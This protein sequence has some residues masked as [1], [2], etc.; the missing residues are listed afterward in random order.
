MYL[1]SSRRSKLMHQLV[2][3]YNTNDKAAKLNWKFP[4]GIDL[5]TILPVKE[6]REVLIYVFYNMHK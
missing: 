3:T 5:N 4:F 6:G 1:D 2:I